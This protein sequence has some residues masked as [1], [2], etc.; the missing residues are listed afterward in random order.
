MSE[1]SLITSP[2]RG[3]VGSLGALAPVAIRERVEHE[4]L[5]QPLT[6]TLSLKG[7]GD[8]FVVSVQP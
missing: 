4:S 7:R 6:L 2:L 8:S 1:F 3:E 5:I